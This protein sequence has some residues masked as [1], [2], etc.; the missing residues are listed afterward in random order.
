MIIESFNEA[1]SFCLSPDTSK[2]KFEFAE[3]ANVFRD[4]QT[5]SALQS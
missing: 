1:L 3:R 2:S 5:K 4:V